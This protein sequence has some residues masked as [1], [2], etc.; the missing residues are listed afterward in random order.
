MDTFP[1]SLTFLAA[2]LRKHLS[3]AWQTFSD[4]RPVP[5]DWHTGIW[6]Q[7]AAQFITF[8][9]KAQARL[10]W[11]Q[12][13]LKV[14]SEVLLTLW[15]RAQTLDPSP[16]GNRLQIASAIICQDSVHARKALLGKYKK[17]QLFCM[18]IYESQPLA[19]Y[20]HS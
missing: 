1:F 18:L 20:R 13:A 12:N 10:A 5:A 19:N 16:P 14:P 6:R 9:T 3:R 15:A 7:R 11:K 2:F 17:P 8:Y 4:N